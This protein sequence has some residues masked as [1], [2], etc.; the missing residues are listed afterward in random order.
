MRNAKPFSRW[1]AIVLAVLVT[2]L[3]LPLGAATVAP[4][5]K[6]DATLSAVASGGGG[7]T[8]KLMNVDPASGQS[9]VE[10]ILRFE[11]DL[12]AVRAQ[13]AL[14]RSVMGNIATV[15]IPVGKLAAVAALSNVLSIEASRAQPLRLDRSVAAARADTL[16]TGTPPNWSAGTGKGVIVGII[17]SGIDFKHA[18][19]RNGDG[20]TRILAIWDQRPA[21]AS[22][23]PPAGY[24]YGGVCT[25][26]MI[27]AANAGDP[28][29]CV[30]KDT[31]SH[32]THVGGIAAGNGQATGNGQLAY[33]MIGM[34]PS[35]D[36][37]ITTGNSY[38]SAAI[39]DSIAWMKATAAALGRPLVINMSFGSYFGARDGTSN[40][41]VGMNNLAGPGVILVAAAGNEANAAIRATGTITQGASDTVGFTIPVA[42]TLATLEVWYP[43]TDSY[44]VNV[45]GPGCAATSTVNPGENPGT[46]NTP[47]GAVEFSSTGVNASNDDR[48]IRVLI[49][50]TA[51]SPLVKGAWKITLVGN[52]VAGGSAPFSIVNG[53]DATGPV[54]TDHIAPVTTEI[55]TDASSPRRVIAVASYNTRTTWNSLNGPNTDN[56]PGAVSDISVF[57]SRG[58][59]RNCS[60]LAKCPPIMKPEITAPGATIMSALTADK[61][62]ATERTS[63]EADGVHYAA[64]GT[65]MATPHIT[66]AVALMLQADPTA[67]PETVKARLYATVQPS[68][69]AVGLPV[70]NAATQDNPANPNFTWGYGILDAAAAVRASGPSTPGTPVTV[71]EFYNAALDHYFITYVPG[72]IAKLDDGTF[73]GWTRTGLSFKAYAATQAGT[74]AVC[75]IYIPPG[76][77]DG[78][79]F[80][81]DTNECDGTMSKNPTFI[82][83]SSTFFYLYPPNLG[84]CGAGQINVYRVFSNRA[85][86]NHRYTTDKAVRDQMVAKGWI[87]EGDGA[88]IVVMCAPQ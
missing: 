67:T 6:L 5:Q 3:A 85:D 77:G 62:S 52:V 81:R 13:G 25:A 80:G 19:F 59:R 36:L 4:V 44:G 61:A 45:T 73:K 64:F 41:E 38:G 17:D 65:S 63:I 86:A 29:A 75:R 34:A 16:R 28:A 27:N 23:A 47:C 37:L 32:G 78:H 12:D 43:G 20:T 39:L 24:T 83:E 15:D 79:F 84:N 48:Q 76:K 66:G 60:N 42:T 68:P 2:P 51:T 1:T 9:M 40:Y 74:S 21:G 70:Y 56:Y 57:S 10:T 71:V 11:G 54:F 49:G 31:D 72:E 55:L 46:V 33:R 18:D 69:F 22:G 88:D 58:P 8:R 7:I 53:E 26:A 14:V 82:L 87:A 30:H 50:S 35:A